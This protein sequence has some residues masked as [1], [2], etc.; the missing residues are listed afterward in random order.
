VLAADDVRYNLV[1]AEDQLRDGLHY[2]CSAA[3]DFHADIPKADD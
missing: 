2:A 3:R 1:N